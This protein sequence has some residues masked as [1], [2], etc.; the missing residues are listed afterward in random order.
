MK[1]ILRGNKISLVLIAGKREQTMFNFRISFFVNI[2]HFIKS[3]IIACSSTEREFLYK[4]RALMN[5]C[6]SLI[7]SLH[8][9]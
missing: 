6:V 8:F 4:D 7:Y 3:V 2:N 1:Y 9:I 5:I